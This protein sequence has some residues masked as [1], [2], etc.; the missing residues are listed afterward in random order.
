MSAIVGITRS[1][2]RLVDPS[3]LERITEALTRRRPDV[4][5]QWVGDDSGALQ[6]LWDGRLDNRSE[7]IALLGSDDARE[8]VRAFAERRPPRWAGR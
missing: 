3:L 6:I 2:G 1:D 7:L 5:S 4:V 8:G